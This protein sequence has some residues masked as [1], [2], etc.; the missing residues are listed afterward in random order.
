MHLDKSLLEN[1]QFVPQVLEEKL[2][3]IIEE[4]VG[5]I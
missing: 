2:L 4:T 5:I 3:K 1:N